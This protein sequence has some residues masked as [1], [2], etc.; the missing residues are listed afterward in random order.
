MTVDAEAPTTALDSL[1]QSNLEANPFAPGALQVSGVIS[2]D[3]QAGYAQVCLSS[4]TNEDCETAGAAPVGEAIGT[5]TTTLTL[6]A[7]GEGVTRTLTLQAFDAA[8][9]ASETQSFT[10][11]LDSVAPTISGTSAWKPS[12][13]CFIGPGARHRGCA[14]LSGSVATVRA[15]SRCWR[16]S[17]PARA[18]RKP[19]ARLDGTNWSFTRACRQRAPFHHHAGLDAAGTWARGTRCRCKPNPARSSTHPRVDRP[20]WRRPP[21][22]PSR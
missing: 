17:N 7:A 20:R 3:L 1:L 5:F 4:A 14:R 2:D 11:A 6:P 8:G 15:W 9:N 12:T 13:C 16:S 10:L 18:S 22:S 19:A 21:G